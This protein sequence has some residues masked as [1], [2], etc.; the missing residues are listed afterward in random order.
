MN[1]HHSDKPETAVPSSAS[2]RYTPHE[3]GFTA[4]NEQFGIFGFGKTQEI[5]KSA[6]E[7][8]FR[9]KFG[10]DGYPW[11][12]PMPEPLWEEPKL[13]PPRK[14]RPEPERDPKI[15][16]FPLFPSPIDDEQPETYGS[17]LHGVIEQ[18]FGK[19]IWGRLHT[20]SFDRLRVQGLVRRILS[21]VKEGDWL[22]H[23]SSALP[24]TRGKAFSLAQKILN[25]EP[26]RL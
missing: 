12:K 23:L 4:K 18:S 3:D 16:P 10:H 5:A 17:I 14:E 15:I 19:A 20:S 25:Q 8:A 6:L 13:P 9:T 21:K 24:M 11:G 26:S 1:R 7:S 2:I 22:F